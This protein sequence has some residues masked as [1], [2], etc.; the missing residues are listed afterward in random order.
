MPAFFEING[1]RIYSYGL[2]SLLGFAAVAAVACWLFRKRSYSGWTLGF[3]AIW[4]LVGLYLGAHLLFGLTQ[5][6]YLAEQ[7]GTWL[8]VSPSFEDVWR[9]L[10]QAFGG[11]V[12][13]GGFLGLLTASSLWLKKACVGSAR[14]DYYDLT[15][16]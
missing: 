15:A 4:G 1:V 9:V 6:P 16:V 5:I 11:M 8:E 13:Y 7:I 2:F 3:L 14:G 12:F 10:M